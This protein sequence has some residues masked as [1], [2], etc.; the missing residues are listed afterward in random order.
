MDP[1]TRVNSVNIFHQIAADYKRQMEL[2]LPDH[3]Q[4]PAAVEEDDS[5]GELPF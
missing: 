2:E 4:Q 1:R 3:N 5:D